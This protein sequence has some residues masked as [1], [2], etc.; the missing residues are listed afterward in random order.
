MQRIAPPFEFSD[1]GALPFKS[2]IALA[3]LMILV[4]STDWAQSSWMTIG[5]VAAVL[6]FGLPHGAYDLQLLASQFGKDA[7][8]H[9]KYSASLTLA[10]YVLLAVSAALLWVLAPTIALIV[11]IAMAGIHF[12]EDWEM[13]EPGLLRAMAGFSPLATIVISSPTDAQMLF[14][15]LS[16]PQSGTALVQAI[17]MA[18]PVILLVT[19]VAHA[20][21][22]KGGNHWW[23]LSQLT[24]LLICALAPAV[25]AFAAFFILFH[26]PIHLVRTRHV[27]A[28]WAWTRFIGYGLAITLIAILSM[29]AF[30]IVAFESL[31][32]SMDTI[33]FMFRLLAIVTVPHLIMHG[34]TT[35]Q[36]QLLLCRAR[37]TMDLRPTD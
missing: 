8:R 12:G 24:A 14:A 30:S 28:Q 4:I 29:A 5:A 23:C 26:S 2:F 33:L 10:S 20:V 1:G 27:L 36:M 18:S 17:V 19:L 35:Q 37:Q 7:P 15:A 6:L 13:L 25:I 22:W 31:T 16:D 11:F 32:P 9:A 34:A 21:T 3:I